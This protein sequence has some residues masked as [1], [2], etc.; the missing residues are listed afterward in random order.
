MLDNLDD[1]EIEKLTQISK[2]YVQ[3]KAL[4]CYSE[5]ID[6]DSKSNIQVIKE[7]RDA[8][9]HTIR[10][11][12]RKLLPENENSLKDYGKDYFKKNLE[13]VIGHVY[14]AA[15][16]ALD[17]I[18]LSIKYKVNVELRHIRGDI[19][20]EVFP[21]YYDIKIKILELEKN[22]AKHRE[23]KDIGHDII[24]RYDDYVEDVEKLKD[25]YKRML[26]RTP[27]IIERFKQDK[28]GWWR[29][30]GIQILIGIILIVLS[31][32][33]TK[34][35]GQNESPS[36]TPTKTTPSIHNPK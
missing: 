7:L 20:T 24:K 15:F 32:V 33:L 35:F 14:R 2:I 19:I 12:H 8:F 6:P 13:K 36:S 18:V 25:D 5:E 10:V 34:Y 29:N 4:I 30:L 9:D 22:V 26:I 21:D 23:Q 31:V 27:L 17:G 16:D 1:E 28:R 3:A 11:F